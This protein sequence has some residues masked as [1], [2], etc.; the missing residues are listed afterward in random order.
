VS[1]SGLAGAGAVLAVLGA[2]LLVVA[3]C[4][5]IGADNVSEAFTVLSTL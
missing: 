3:I 5:T 4:L 1:V 2:I